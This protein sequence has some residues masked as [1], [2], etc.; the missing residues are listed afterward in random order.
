VDLRGS[1]SS[2]VAGYCITSGE[3]SSSIT[4]HNKS[5]DSSVGIALG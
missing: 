4:L 1:L 5:H 2:T 3:V